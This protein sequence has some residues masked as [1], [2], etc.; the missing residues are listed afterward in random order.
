MAGNEHGPV[1]SR[2]QGETALYCLQGSLSPVGIVPPFELGD[3]RPL[4]QMLSRDPMAN[5][6]TIKL[7]SLPLSSS[8]C[9][10]CGLW[11]ACLLVLPVPPLAL[12]AF[13]YNLSSLL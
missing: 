8:F 10:S 11:T 7:A 12:S 2:Q 6:G 13:T 9:W 3:V 4:L 1:D 5:K